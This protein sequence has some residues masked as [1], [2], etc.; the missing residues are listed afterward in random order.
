M[1]FHVKIFSENEASSLL[2]GLP[3]IEC[4]SI[5]ISREMAPAH[6]ELMKLR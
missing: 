5:D 6:T 1:H 3:I 4:I 2:T